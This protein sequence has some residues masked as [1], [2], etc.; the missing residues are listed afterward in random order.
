MWK[1][2][3][4]PRLSLMVLLLLL[5]GLSLPDPRL[6]AQGFGSLPDLVVKSLQLSNEQPLAGESLTLTATIANTG[7]G[8]AE[9]FFNVSFLV[10]R[11]QIGRRQLNGLRARQQ[12]TVQVSWKAQLG[13]H[14]LE[15]EVDQP[16]GRI[17]ES[18]ETNND[19]RRK[20]TVLPLQG[21]RSLTGELLGAVAQGLEGAGQSLQLKPDPDLFKL[22]N[23]LTE[24]LGAASGAFSQA[25]S[26]LEG[27]PAGLPAQLAQ[28]P[29]VQ[30]SSTFSGLYAD[31]AQSLKQA[32]RALSQ[33]NLTSAEAGLD[34][35]KDRLAQLAEL[36]LA[37][38]RLTSLAQAAVTLQQVIEQTKQ[39]EKALGGDQNV[40]VNQVITD[41]LA[42]LSATGQDMVSAGQ[43]TVQSASQRMV[44][45]RDAE[46]KPVQ[47]YFSGQ[48]LE[49]GAPGARSLQW[50]LF[51][52]AGKLLAQ[53]QTKSERL[54]WS[55]HTDDGAPLP[56]GRYFY[57]AKVT[58]GREARV[59]LGTLTAESATKSSTN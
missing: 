4:A 31:L 5:I 48:E 29:Q 7:F 41:L 56:A 1:S 24:A 43:Q 37:G 23:R 55:G 32:Q 44:R 17:V 14:T 8:N 50:E 15:V 59:E 35:T 9:G 36:S 47:R 16:F 26:S 45:F 19:L 11:S 49:I 38:I 46:G 25:A 51:D 53:M 58:E 33:A 13:T 21:V 12:A 3:I 2:D 22:L 27:A 6:E 10:D 40:P 57:R 20:I 28:E 34:R 39:L 30:M 54:R 52:P 18:N 42:Q